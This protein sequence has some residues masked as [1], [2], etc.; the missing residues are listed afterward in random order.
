MENFW[1]FEIENFRKSWISNENCRKSKK[2]QLKSN[3]SNFL[4]SKSFGFFSN[5]F[6]NR[7]RKISTEA[8][9]KILVP[10]KCWDSLRQ[11]TFRVRLANTY[12]K[13]PNSRNFSLRDSSRDPRIST[14]CGIT[15]L[16]AEYQCK[17]TCISFQLV[18]V[19]LSFWFLSNDIH[20][21]I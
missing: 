7:S 10:G 3:F 8:I 9:F 17:L 14:E 6:S 20:F 18:W 15:C 5:F 21:Y 2:I 1:F 11:K 19:Q 16:H 12:S 13:Y 4:T